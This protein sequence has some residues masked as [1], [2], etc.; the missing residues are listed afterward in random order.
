[1][2]T[3]WTKSGATTASWDIIKQ[4]VGIRRRAIVFVILLISQ[5]LTG[6]L[7]SY[8]QTSLAR[9]QEQEQQRTSIK[10]W[11]EVITQT[12]G[13]MERTTERFLSQ[14]EV[15]TLLSELDQIARTTRVKVP[16]ITVTP[17]QEGDNSI[18]NL[19][20][21][22]TIEGQ[23][24]DFRSYLAEVER[25]PRFLVIEELHLAATSHAS[26]ELRIQAKMAVPLKKGMG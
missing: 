19:V 9:Q 16:V 18:T 2:I 15:P 1:M 26:Q 13:D 14:Q 7:V 8:Q 11:Q 12:R 23:Y 22:L 3:V 20:L 24:A 6:W 21:S 5:L 17:A 10:H 25:S 4:D